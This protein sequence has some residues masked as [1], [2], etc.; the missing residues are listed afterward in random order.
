M[1]GVEL[2]V[3]RE[4]FETGRGVARVKPR[5][6]VPDD[7]RG[8]ARLTCRQKPEHL[9]PP[10]AEHARAAAHDGTGGLQRLDRDVRRAVAYIKDAGPAGEERLR[11]VRVLHRAL[12]IDSFISEEAKT[13]DP[14]PA[15]RRRGR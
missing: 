8:N 1:H 14:R 3:R 4:P 5:V 12:S 9:E 7:H 10:A 13:N 11:Q 2:A 15:R 6:G